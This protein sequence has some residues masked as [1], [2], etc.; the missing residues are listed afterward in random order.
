MKTEYQEANRANRQ[1][2]GM[3]PDDQLTDKDKVGF[4]SLIYD[5][6]KVNLDEAD[7]AMDEVITLNSEITNVLQ[8]DLETLNRVND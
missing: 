4:A 3:S 1:N 2:E 6:A 7:R 5:D 8:K